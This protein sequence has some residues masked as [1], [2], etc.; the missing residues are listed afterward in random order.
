MTTDDLLI[1]EDLMLLLMDDDGASVQGAGT[2]HY[3]LGGALLT[4]LALLGRVE[5]D[6]TG[7]V[8][9]PRVT[10]RAQGRSRTCRCSPPTTPW[11]GGPGACS[12]CCSHW[13]VTCGGWFATGWW[14]AGCCAGRS[15]VGSACSAARGGRPT[16]RGTRRS[17]G[18]ASGGCWRTARP[19]T[20]VPR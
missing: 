18:C 10:P 1:V 4:E 19:P 16:T 5:T 8:N 15:P 9:G 17:C 20:L 6:G 12:P 13:A 11:P 14:S 7:I 3:T 2:L